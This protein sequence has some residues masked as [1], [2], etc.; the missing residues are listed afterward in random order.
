M[1]FDQANRVHTFLREES[2][3]VRDEH[4]EDAKLH[5][6]WT[7]VLGSGLLGTYSSCE[8]AT[9]EDV[10]LM[11]GCPLHVRRRL[12][13]FARLLSKAAS[14]AIERSGLQKSDI[15]VG[16]VVKLQF[17]K[18]DVEAASKPALQEL[19]FEPPDEPDL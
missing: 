8:T 10:L 15:S 9:C 3:R 17:A 7:A 19:D 2:N 11:S 1:D 16:A 14:R 12:L 6:Q 4:P 18:A 13:R 5:H